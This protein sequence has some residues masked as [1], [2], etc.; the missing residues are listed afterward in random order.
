MRCR[1]NLHLLYSTDA[2]DF[3]K[4]TH[5]QVV[6]GEPYTGQV[7][8]DAYFIDSNNIVGLTTTQNFGDFQSGSLSTPIEP[9]LKLYGPYAYCSSVSRRKQQ[10]RVFFAG[11][12]ANFADG[13][14]LYMTVSGGRMLGL[15]PVKF[16][17]PVRAICTGED[18]T[19][20]EVTFFGDDVGRVYQ[21]DTGLVFDDEP[22]T[23]FMRLTFHHFKNPAYRKRFRHATFDM[24]VEDT[25]HL[26]MSADFDYADPDIATHVVRYFDQDW[27]V[28]GLWEVS[29][30]DEFYWDSKLVAEANLDICGTGRNMALLI[31]NPGTSGGAH[32][33]NG[34][35]VHY[36]DRRLVR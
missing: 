19:G 14:G 21:L 31:Y 9:F 11:G 24:D 23:G 10:Y 34:V 2:G 1:N 33:I 7:L 36:S 20:G 18:N 6:G 28:G 35:V 3:L 26:Q 16:P 27:G 8:G 4:K 30:W 17:D 25:I 32:A 5:S 13:V 22:L 29:N 12:D 15:M